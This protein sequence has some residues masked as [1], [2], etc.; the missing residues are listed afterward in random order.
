MQLEE[1]I[2]QAFD[3]KF[4]EIGEEAWHDIGSD[5]IF[6]YGWAACLAAQPTRVTDLTTKLRKLPSSENMANRHAEVM[7]A[8]AA[9]IERYYG[10]M[11]A[12]KQTAETRDRQLAEAMEKRVTERVE[13]RVAEQ[14]NK[15][16]GYVTT[17]RNGTQH[18]Y[19]A[20]PYLDNAVKCDTVYLKTAEYSFDELTHM[21]MAAANKEGLKIN[22]K[23]VQWTKKGKNET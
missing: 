2:Q 14:S 19:E 10:G 18:F 23:V 16:Y 3:A 6:E 11:I 22:L 21:L 12:W 15:P 9:E 8:A 4:T 7:L 17:L 20:L 13:A 5:K 1:R